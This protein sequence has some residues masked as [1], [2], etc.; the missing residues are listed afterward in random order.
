MIELTILMPCLNESE[1]LAV[2][3][4]KA[5]RFL[6]EN[7]IE[8]EILIAD[9]GSTDDSPA[10]ACREGARVVQVLRMGYGCALQ[11]GISE[12]RG[13]YTIMGDADDSYDFS[14]LSLFVEKLRQGCDLVMGN[15][16]K[17][18]IRKGAMPLLHRY[19]GNPV[20]SSAGRLFFHSGVGDFHCGLRG[21]NTE[22][23]RELR[24]VTPGMEFASEMVVKATLMEYRIAEVPTILYPDGRSGPTHLNSWRDG[25]RHLV[26]L[27]I[28]S[29]KWL[30]FVPAL[31]LFL[32]STIGL[33]VLLTGFPEIEGAGPKIH[34]LTIAGALVILSYQLLLFAIFIKIY[35]MNQG[36]YPARKRHMLFFKF[37]T[38][39]RGILAGILIL[40][41]GLAVFAVLVNSSA[42]PDIP[43]IQAIKESFGLLIPAITLVSLGIQTI[44]SSFF[45]RILGINPQVYFR[46]EGI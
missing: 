16:F 7:G 9:N 1:T 29:P 37:F 11:G 2:C 35:S 31:L 19:L 10:I 40:I 5:R 27:L 14:E 17:G 44:F 34:T 25:W 24:L 15:R 30:F 43:Q 8:G 33:T 42:D 22:R 28:Y 36:F 26:F 45:L 13:K 18:G 41:T 23:I 39:E 12:A 46:H 20:L 21:F 3:I 38:L 32:G 6:V 4:A